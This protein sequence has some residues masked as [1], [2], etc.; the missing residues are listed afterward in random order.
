MTMSAQR[1]PLHKQQKSALRLHHHACGTGS[2]WWTKPEQQAS[3][4]LPRCTPAGSLTPPT[5]PRAKSRQPEKGPLRSQAGAAHGNGYL[6]RSRCAWSSRLTP[7]GKQPPRAQQL[8]DGWGPPWP[9]SF[10]LPDNTRDTKWWQIRQHLGGQVPR[11]SILVGA[12]LPQRAVLAPCS[13]CPQKEE[14]GEHV[15]S[16]NG[17]HPGVALHLLTLPPGDTVLGARQEGSTKKP[18]DFPT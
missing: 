1:G 16:H 8:P 17:D 6:C 10:L 13:D 3:L 12:W 11:G 5:Q 14:E 2:P 15:F 18:F 9:P 4:H 7:L